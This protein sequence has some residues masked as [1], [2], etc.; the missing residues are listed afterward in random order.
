MKML[1]RLRVAMILMLWLSGV[2]LASLNPE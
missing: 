2:S 1:R